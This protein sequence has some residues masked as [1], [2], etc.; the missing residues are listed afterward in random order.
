MLD[1]THVP[2]I[3]FWADRHHK[4]RVIRSKLE[5]LDC[6]DG[7]EL[8][9]HLARYCAHLDSKFPGSRVSYAWE[10]AEPNSNRAIAE[11]DTAEYLQWCEAE[12]ED[13]CVL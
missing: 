6:V 4:V 10:F 1:P 2:F 9:W 12:E 11:S 7:S 5:T 8:D 3:S 13:W